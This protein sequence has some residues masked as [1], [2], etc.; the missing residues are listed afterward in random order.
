MTFKVRFRPQ[1]VYFGNVTYN[2]GREGYFETGTE[3]FIK[4]Y[5]APHDVMYAKLKYYKMQYKAYV[6]GTPNYISVNN[7]VS[8]ASLIEEEKQNDLV[9]ISQIKLY[10]LKYKLTK[11]TQKD[12]S[13]KKILK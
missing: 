13:K 11:L 9:T 1:D 7:L 5:Y 10:L 3:A 2:A 6:D 12:D 4:T 8:L